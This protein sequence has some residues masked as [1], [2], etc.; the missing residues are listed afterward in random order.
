MAGAMTNAYVLFTFALIVSAAL[1][2][3]ARPDTV[4][5]IADL[6]EIPQDCRDALG[7]NFVD[8]R[9]IAM[10][11]QRRLAQEYRQAILAPWRDDYS[12]SQAGQVRA[13]LD[14]YT[15]NPGCGENLL[16]REPGWA[17]GMLPIA[18]LT[19]YPNCRRR[20]I[21]VR[22][23]S[24]RQLPT[25]EAVFRL[26]GRGEGSPFDRLQESAMWA[27]TPLLVSHVSAGG[28][29]VWVQ[30]CFAAGWVSAGDV[31]YVD[32]EL[33]A[34]WRSHPMAAIVRDGVC[35]RGAGGA[36]ITTEHI[37][38]VLPLSRSARPD[39]DKSLEVLAAAR[40]PDGAAK[41]V[42]VR[43]A[44]GEAEVFPVPATTGRLADLADL[45]L[46]Q[47]YGW[48]GLYE[49]RDCS[50]MTRDLLAPLGVYLP[51]NSSEQAKA[52]KVVSL[53]GMSPAARERRIL[54]DGKGMLTLLGAP[55]HI[56]LYLGQRDGRALIMH[57]TWGVKVRNPDGSEGRKPIGCCCI[58]TL[59]PGRE[60]PDIML[61]EA[62]LRH[63]I[64]VMVLLPGTD[65]AEAKP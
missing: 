17:A 16:P 15:C 49:Q 34:A 10:D 19:D 55:G 44:P 29:W 65:D 37:G 52:G 6:R 51:R 11:T 3:C 21:T 43:L 61:P 24:I 8:G 14:N 48:G 57:N 42:R 33:I 45:M 41:A 23:T 30:S 36:F 28:A 20:A 40:M 26:P 63:A 1:T 39:A 59:Q 22:N 25:V 18:D 54:A 9:L 32:D 62:D 7:G 60:L 56:M 53:A 5:P 31:A 50:A 12:P 38:A 64:E 4:L 35:L 46:G 27:N 13:L 58:T 2:G 47:P